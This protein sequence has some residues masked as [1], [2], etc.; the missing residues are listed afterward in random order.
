MHL[1]KGEC[2]VLNKFIISN[3]GPK[4]RIL[5]ITKKDE[6][7]ICS[8]LH[9][10]TAI[11]VNTTEK[12][13][14]VV[15]CYVSFI[16]DFSSSN[17]GIETY[18]ILSLTFVSNAIRFITYLINNNILLILNNLLCFLHFY[19]KSNKF[20][21]HCN[22]FFVCCWFFLKH[23]K[24]GMGPTKSNTIVTVDVLQTTTTDRLH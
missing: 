24:G 8:K 21:K 12:K 2:T 20:I 3:V 4:L 1:S 23:F 22:M 18:L 16:Y 9:L 5:V 7:L 17:L 19:G 13:F 10:F 6:L 15:E 11:P 14:L